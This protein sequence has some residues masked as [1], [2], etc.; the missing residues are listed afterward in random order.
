MAAG[1]PSLAGDR[2]CTRV[3]PCGFQESTGNFFKSE[4]APP[5]TIPIK[6]ICRAG[7]LLNRWSSKNSSVLPQTSR[8]AFP[9]ACFLSDCKRHV[10][11]LR[12]CESQGSSRDV[13]AR[14]QT[15]GPMPLEFLCP[16][17]RKCREQEP[18]TPVIFLLLF[19]VS[20][21]ESNRLEQPSARPTLGPGKTHP[22]DTNPSLRFLAPPQTKCSA[23]V[24]RPLLNNPHSMRP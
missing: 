8:A 22:R 3:R 21:S 15:H 24:P 19:L 23:N 10:E 6:S 7:R 20:R 4:R 14:L 13:G 12:K 18:A 17:R 5:H 1:Q 9:D 11:L 2:F 16:R